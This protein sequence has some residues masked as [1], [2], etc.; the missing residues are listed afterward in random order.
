MT[1]TAATASG[2]GSWQAFDVHVETAAGCTDLRANIERP[3]QGD[4]K[5]RRITV[6][7]WVATNPPASAVEVVDEEGRRVLRLPVDIRRPDIEAAFPDLSGAPHHG[8][9]GTILAGTQHGLVRLRLHAVTGGGAGP[10][11]GTITLAPRP[12]P[13]SALVSIIVPCFNQAE[14]LGESIESALAQT[15]PH[16]EV[17]V[18][19]DG[20]TDNTCA[21]AATFP[22]IRVVSRP[23]GGLPAARN[24]GLTSVSGRYTVFLD[25]DDRLVPQ[26]VA[27]GVDALQARPGH[28]AA[29]G[30][31]QEVDVTGGP[32]PTPPLARLRGEPYEALLRTNWTGGAPTAV[33]RRDALDAVGWFDESLPAAEDYE[34][35]LRIVRTTSV[36]RHGQVVVEYRRHAGTMSTDPLLM[37]E[38]VLRVLDLQ[39]RHVA[40]EPRLRTAWREG[41]RFWR[42]YYGATVADTIA[43]AMIDHRWP[44]GLSG[45][46]PFAWRRPRE[47]VRL[48]ARAATSIPS[49]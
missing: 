46:A 48:A 47:A 18:V 1:G 21:V 32:L 27:I 30:W 37:L 19:D 17:V 15:H 12:A 26:A 8:F 9:H 6:A 24:T 2:D 31:Y 22:G 36:H 10:A 33:Y 20:S 25:A 42:Q 43:V 40:H 45:L 23:N 11:I 3:T 38:Q 4:G 35:N 34:L 28:S 29:F 5:T 13:P 41:R 14:F 16:V 44:S 49:R 39:W 7:G